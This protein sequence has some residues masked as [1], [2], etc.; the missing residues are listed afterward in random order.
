M[1]SQKIRDTLI[2][3]ASEKCANKKKSENVSYVFRKAPGSQQQSMRDSTR[4]G[5]PLPVGV[6]NDDLSGLMAYPARIQYE[7]LRNPLQDLLVA[8]RVQD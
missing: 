1:T 8:M 2:S 4:L 5:S 6:G 7:P 3:S